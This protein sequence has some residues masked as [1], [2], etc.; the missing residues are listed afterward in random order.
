MFPETPTREGE[1]YEL[2]LSVSPS[3]NR[4]PHP[5]GED[6]WGTMPKPIVMRKSLS[7]A[8]LS[9]L[10]TRAS[11]QSPTKSDWRQRAGQPVRRASAEPEDDD[12]NSPGGGG[13]FAFEMEM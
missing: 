3:P 2:S 4:E 5:P 10:L 8:E 7:G 13:D 1:E 9:Q 12:S 11:R 6:G